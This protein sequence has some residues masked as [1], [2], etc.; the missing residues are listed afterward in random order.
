[1]HQTL[2][3]HGFR[4]TQETDAGPLLVFPSYF[5][6]ER[7]DQIDHPRIF[8][9][10]RFSGALEELY[11]TLVVKLHHTRTFET[12]ELWRNAAD[13]VA[14]GGKVG[15][16]M[17]KLGETTECDGRLAQRFSNNEIPQCGMNGKNDLLYAIY[18]RH[19]FE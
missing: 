8:G 13:F 1:M 19:F 6:R 15:L 10:F 18:A 14:D 16:K 5:N 7:R 4:L 11:A 17:K 12:E 9:T 2:V 3:D